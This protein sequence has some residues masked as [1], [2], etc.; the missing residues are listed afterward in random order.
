MYQACVDVEA[1]LQTGLFTGR[2]KTSTGLTQ[3][4][5]AAVRS[6]EAL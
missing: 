2:A 6:L 4:I 1:P 3:R 5:E